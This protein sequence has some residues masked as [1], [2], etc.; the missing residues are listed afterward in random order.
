MKNKLLLLVVSFFIFAPSSKAYLCDNSTKVEYQEMAKNISVNYEYTESD[1]DVNFSIK[2]S[3]IPTDFIVLDVINNKKYYS[4]SNSSEILIEN[5]SKNTSYRFDISKNEIACGSIVFY[6][7]YINIPA[8]NKY[9]KDAICEGIE[10]Y[11]LCN[12]WLNVT[13]SYD[14]WKNKIIEYKNS[15]NKEEEI[16]EEK[17]KS[18]MEKIIEFYSNYYMFIL[19]GIIIV[20]CSGIYLYNKKHDLF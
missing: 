6:S 7:H 3:N 20:S 8:Y 11:K 5:V 15:L 2:I 4:S 17:E 1:D 9:Y 13:I 18:W 12:K 14:E 16:P 10:D 19:P